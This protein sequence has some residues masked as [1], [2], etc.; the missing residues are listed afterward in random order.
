MDENK[1]YEELNRT[2]KAG[3]LA[4]FLAARYAQMG[5][6]RSAAQAAGLLSEDT[7]ADVAF[8]VGVN[9]PSSE[10]VLAVQVIL[11]NTAQAVADVSDAALAVEP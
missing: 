6:L 4:A 7:W 3:K 9:P 11:R 2:I 10:T 1:L 8:L 5:S